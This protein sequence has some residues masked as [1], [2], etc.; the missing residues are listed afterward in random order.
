MSL[1][2]ENDRSHLEDG[3]RTMLHRLAAD[4]TER[5]PA[6]DD[7]VGRHEPAAPALGLS[8]IPEVRNR[9]SRP[10]RG[11]RLTMPSPVS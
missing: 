1:L 9:R 10:E 7:L 8:S 3:V 2:H 11:A 6:W 5:P 4:V